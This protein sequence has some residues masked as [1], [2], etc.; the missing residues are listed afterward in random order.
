MLDASDQLLCLVDHD[1]RL[2]DIG[3]GADELLGWEATHR[4]TPIQDGVHPED[5]PRLM[6]ALGHSWSDR[7]TAVLELR[8]RG[9]TGDWDRVRCQISPLGE[10]DPPRYAM[11]IRLSE[12]DEETTA[13]RATRFEGHLWRIALE[14]QAA[15]IGDRSS[16]RDAWWADPAVAGLS[17]R[18]ADILRR[19]VRG[20]RVADI[21]QELVIT[22]STVRNHLSGIYEKFGVH[23]QAALMSRLMRGGVEHSA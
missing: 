8:M 5:A 23:S 2:A 12:M 1:G 22:E 14:L 18:Q 19:V 9:R 15:R 13:D 17:E 7:R 21:A 6:L 20:E 16:L 10:H 11:A 3:A 4:G